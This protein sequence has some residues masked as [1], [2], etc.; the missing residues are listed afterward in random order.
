MVYK[1]PP[2]GEVNHIWPLAYVLYIRDMHE[3]LQSNCQLHGKLQWRRNLTFWPT[4]EIKVLLYS[5][6]HR[7]LNVQ[8]KKKKKKKK[9]KIFCTSAL[10]IGFC[11]HCSET[12]ECVMRKWR[13]LALVFSRRCTVGQNWQKPHLI[14]ITWTSSAVYHK[15]RWNHFTVR[16]PNGTRLRQRKELYEYSSVS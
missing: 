11:P 4:D 2:G 5:A 15:V 12:E 8:R 1:I 10:S 13:E 6:I 14:E 7:M 16:R 9:K 3:L